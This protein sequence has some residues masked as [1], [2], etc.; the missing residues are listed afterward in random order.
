MLHTVRRVLSLYVL[1]I[2]L[3]AC[4]SRA[5]FY[6]HTSV[7]IGSPAYGQV[8]STAARGHSE[9]HRMFCL[10]SFYSSNLNNITTTYL[11]SFKDT[12]EKTCQSR[13]IGI[14]TDSKA[15]ETK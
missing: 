7:Y 15:V 12:G 5:N 3:L 11:T 4:E 10:N 9:K 8:L 6:R 13:P 14:K 1:S 2:F